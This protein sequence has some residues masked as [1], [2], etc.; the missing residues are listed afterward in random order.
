MLGTVNLGGL[1]EGFS[2][3]LPHWCFGITILVGLV[4]SGFTGAETVLGIFVAGCTST[5]SGNKNYVCI[6]KSLT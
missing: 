1:Y 3:A 2:P 4:A 5:L 6:T